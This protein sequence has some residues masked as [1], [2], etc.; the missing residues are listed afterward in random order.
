MAD[1]PL[2][3]TDNFPARQSML[4]ELQLPAVQKLASQAGMRGLSVYVMNFDEPVQDIH[5]GRV[6]AVPSNLTT[7]LQASLSALDIAVICCGHVLTV[8]QVLACCT[9]AT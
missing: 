7:I 4:A 6:P 2:S 8:Q 9:D 1:K 5:A 3:E